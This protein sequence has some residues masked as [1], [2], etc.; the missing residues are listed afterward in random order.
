MRILLV[1]NNVPSP[2]HAATT[3]A[4]Y[5]IKYAK[6]YR[7]NISLIAFKRES[8]IH[9]LIIQSCETIDTIELLRIPG[10][11]VKSLV[12]SLKETLSYTNLTRSHSFIAFSYSTRMQKLIDKTLRE[13]NFDILFVDY[14]MIHYRYDF[15][16]KVLEVRD[17]VLNSYA[18]LY[19]FETSLF[20]K[21]FWLLRFYH[22]KFFYIPKYLKFDACII[23]SEPDNRIIR[24]SLPKLNSIVVPYGVD[25]DYF[26]P[27]YFEEE[28]PSIIYVGDMSYPH[29][30]NAV[31]YFYRK[32][33]PKVKKEFPKLKFFIVGRN[34]TREIIKLMRLDDSIVVTGY[35]EDVRPYISKASVVVVPTITEAGIKTKI[36][37]AMAMGK[38]IVSTSIGVRGIDAMPEKNVIIADEPKVF[39]DRVVELLRD[40][41]LRK[42][43]G[44]NAR[45]FVEERYSWEK[46]TD[47]LNNVFQQVVEKR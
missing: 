6:K 25:I 27:L 42:R 18:S 46:M 35:V 17:A 41:K 22:L 21:I 24:E 11:F 8:H 34:P 36:L 29:N 12:K 31:L 9:P 47:I 7:H 26:K 45:K 39:A 20:K 2:H 4:F 1:W 33:F 37:E 38:P 32:I 3:R 5:L 14:G 23:V 30:V 16:P 40:E 44:V 10:T 43:I 13:N 19:R 28:Y 15:T